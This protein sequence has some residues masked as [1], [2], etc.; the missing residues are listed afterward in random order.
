[1]NKVLIFSGSAGSGKGTV[2]AKLR[3]MDPRF[4]L[5]VSMTTRLPRPGEENGREYYFV[6]RR[7][8]QKALRFK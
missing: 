1:M 6:T 8:F 4:R 2:L 3:E 7:E 5:S